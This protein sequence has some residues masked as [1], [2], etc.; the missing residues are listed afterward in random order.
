MS[1]K[2][3]PWSQENLIEPADFAQQLASQS[4]QLSIFCTGFPV[5]YRAAH[6]TDAILTGPCSK[7]EGLAELR[8]QTAALPLDREIVLYCGCCPF[9]HCPN[10]RPAFTALHERGF[11]QIKVLHI[12]S[13]LHGD[14]ITKGY[15]TK[16]V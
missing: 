1:Q 16:K 8:K 12:A 4:A 10:I 5:L 13:N 15:P 7:P 6:I 3:D 9:D 14:W 2:K 11:R